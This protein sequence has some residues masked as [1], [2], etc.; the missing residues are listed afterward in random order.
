MKR[1]LLALA[2]AG[3]G[4][5]V[6]YAQPDILTDGVFIFHSPPGLVYTSD[7]TDYCPV[8]AQYAI[9]R[10]DQENPQVMS[11]TGAVWYVL[12]A[13][14]DA[15][16]W[17]GTE[18][19]LG[20]YDP[21][22]VGIAAYGQCPTSA[23]VI[24]YGTWPGPNTGISLAAAGTPW[25]GNFQPVYWFGAYAYYPGLVPLT[26]HPG[27]GFGGFADCLTPPT[28]YP[29][30]AYGAMG[31]YQT[32]VPACPPVPTQHVCCVGELCYLVLTADECAAMGGVY[33]PE[34]DS[35]GPP[36]PCEVIPVPA[37]CCI[38][39][40]CFLVLED[41]CAAMGG[42]WHPE[43][44]DCGPPNPCDIYTP[45]EPSSWGAIK[46]IYR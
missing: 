16:H 42:I 4:V 38:G 18:F 31:L 2:L 44:P 37:V 45:A 9:T 23:L 3:L 19:G 6:A 28:S 36:N 32:G 20:A 11:G 40:E 46:A 35:C 34:W 24:P 17:C 30:Y 8:Y 25:D 21:G 15:K 33:H 13:W 12:A 7:I 14:N 26:A 5:G 1:V 41:E 29:A 22:I 27:T 43:F 10:C 39:H